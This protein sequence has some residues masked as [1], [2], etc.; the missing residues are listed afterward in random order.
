MKTW[1][2]RWA[3]VACFLGVL[4]LPLCASA[5]EVDWDPDRTYTGPVLSVSGTVFRVHPEFDVFAIRG[6]DGGVYSPINLPVR[7]WDEGREVDV[8]IRDRHDIKVL[9]L[10]GAIVELLRIRD[11]T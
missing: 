5:D 9:K 10:D 11:A 6:D 8:E 2:C 4:I 1:A 3:S 7:F